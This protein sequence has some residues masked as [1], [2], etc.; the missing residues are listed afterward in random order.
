GLPI[1]EVRGRGLLLAIGLDRPLAQET[2]RAALE[3]GLLVNPIG[4][5]TIRLAPPLTIGEKEEELAV[6]GIERALSR[7]SASEGAA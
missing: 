7:A 3:E 1:A 4:A 2:A 5:N 6:A